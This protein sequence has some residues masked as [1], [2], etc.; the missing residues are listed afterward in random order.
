MKHTSIT[1][2]FACGEK[3]LNEAAKFFGLKKANR[4][5]Y[6]RFL[7]VLIAAG[8]REIQKETGAIQPE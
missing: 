1:M 5:H 2:K 6:R 7:N 3:E 4:E 8:D